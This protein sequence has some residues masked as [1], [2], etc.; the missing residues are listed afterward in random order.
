VADDLI[1]GV[2]GKPFGIRGEVYVR[3]DPDLDHDFAPGTTYTL[4][5]G[6]RLVAASTHVH[7]NRRLL[8]FEGVADRDEA[9]A[10]RG[11]ILSVP[12]DAVALDEEARWAADLV[13]REVRDPE[14]ALLGTVAGFL[15]GPAHDYL[16]LARPG[17]REALVPL[18]EDLVDLDAGAAG[19]QVVLRPIPGLLDDDAVE[20]GGPA[21][22][23]SA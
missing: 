3:A 5:D 10:L 22:T 18:H 8:A 16:V 2:I 19:D 20:A 9:E 23:G 21:P 15:D 11:A 4:A 17:G 7:G 13:G 1:V 12:R 14:G 6:R